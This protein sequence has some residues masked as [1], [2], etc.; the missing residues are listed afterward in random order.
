MPQVFGT[1]AK[2]K[3]S[4]HV[5][6][7]KEAPFAKDVGIE[8]RQISDTLPNTLL[9]IEA[10]D[11]MAEIWT[12]PGGLEFDPSDPLKCLG[13]TR[14]FVGALMDGVVREFRNIN[15]EYFSKLVRHRDNQKVD[16]TAD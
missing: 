9:M 6:T 10:G 2:G 16:P 14:T 7:G 3:T 13:K 5:F 1:N 15:P 11:D 4:M 12:K 8:F